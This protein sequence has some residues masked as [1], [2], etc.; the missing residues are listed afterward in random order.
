M[1]SG[2][3]PK[4][5]TV[6]NRIKKKQLKLAQLFP[7]N[8]GQFYKFHCIWGVLLRNGPRNFFY[9]S[10]SA[11]EPLTDSWPGGVGSIGIIHFTV[12]HSWI[13]SVWNPLSLRVWHGRLIPP[14]WS[15]NA[16]RSIVIRMRCLWDRK[17]TWLGLLVSISCSW[18]NIIA[19]KIRFG[20]GL[21]V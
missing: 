20:L 14:P 13:I 8:Q 21:K 19:C 11:A 3:H 6:P 1:V 17:C 7:M 10:C 4:R 5:Y 16:G 2:K 9:P 15:Q 12:H 18:N